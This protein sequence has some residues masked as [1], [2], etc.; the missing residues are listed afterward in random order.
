MIERIL[1]ATSEQTAVADADPNASVIENINKTFSR[2]LPAGFRLWSFWEALPSEDGGSIVVDKYSAIINHDDEESMR[3][4]AN[5]LGVARFPDRADPNYCEIKDV[6]MRSIDDISEQLSSPE[7]IQDELLA[8][9]EYLGISDIEQSEEDELYQLSDAQVENTCQWLLQKPSFIMWSDENAEVSSQSRRCRLLWV[10]G[11]PGSGKTHLSAAVVNHLKPSRNCYYYFLKH[12]DGSK[13]DI[14]GLLKS[15]ALQI[16]RRD[17]KVR[18][19]LLEMVQ[20]QHLERDSS[21]YIV[22]WK[23]VYEKYILTRRSSMQYWVFDAIDEGRGGLNLIELL[24]KIPQQFQCRIFLTSRFDESLDR[25]LLSPDVYH[26]KITYAESREDIRL[27]LQQKADDVLQ[28]API[29]KVPEYIE[30]ILDRSK[31]SFLWTS[32]VAERLASVYAEERIDEVLDNMPAEMNGFYTEILRNMSRSP[33]ID[34]AQTILRWTVCSVRPLTLDQ[35]RLAIRLDLGQNV[36][37]IDAAVRK[38]CGQLVSI[39]QEKVLLAH[40]TVREFLLGSAIHEDEDISQ[41]ALDKATSHARLGEVCLMALGSNVAQS[42]VR[43]DPISR[44]RVN[45]RSRPKISSNLDPFYDYAS[46]YFSEHIVK[47]G[48]PGSSTPV[49]DLEEF[50]QVHVREWIEHAA[51]KGDLTRLIV[52][53]RNLKSF[54]DTRVVFQ[55]RPGYLDVIR[56][57]ADDLIYLVTYFGKFLL[58]VP[59]SIQSTIPPLCPKNSM[60]AHNFGR[61]PQGLEVVGFYPR[62]WAD[63]IS[64]TLFEHDTCSAL[65]CSAEYYAVG[66]KAGWIVAFDAV[67]CQELWRVQKTVDLKFLQ[68]V[69]SSNS[70]VVSSRTSLA[71]YDCED[72]KQLWETPLKLQHRAMTVLED[73][74]ESEVWAFTTK[75]TIAVFNLE[76]GQEIDRFNWKPKS[77]PQRVF[78]CGDELRWLALAYRNQPLE[79][80]ELEDLE[81]TQ[82]ADV[83]SSTETVAFNPTK[84]TLIMALFDGEIRVLQMWNW[85][86]KC[87]IK[88]PVA[89]LACSNDGELVLAGNNSG[90]IYILK[91]DNLECI[92]QIQGEGHEIVSL[93]FSADDRRFIDIRRQLFNIWEPSAL[94][95]RKEVEK[96]S[97]EESQRN[98]SYSTAPSGLMQAFLRGSGSRVTAMALD[99]ARH[100]V[101]CGKENGH[102]T[103]HETTHHGRAKQK[104]YE[105]DGSAVSYMDWSM[106]RQVLVTCDR[107]SRVLVHEV[108]F[109]RQRTSTGVREAWVLGKKLLEKQLDVAVRQVLFTGSGELLMVST[110]AQDCL[111][112]LDDK[113]IF[114]HSCPQS[115][116]T[117]TISQK[118]APVLAR[119]D[120]LVEVELTSVH[121]VTG[122]PDGET[123]LQDLSIDQADGDIFEIAAPH[124]RI[125]RFG[126]GVWAAYDFNPLSRPILWKLPGSSNNDTHAARTLAHLQQIAPSI[127]HLVGEY[128]ARLVFIDVRGWICSVG[129]DYGSQ[130]DQIWYHFPIPHYWQRADHQPLFLVT[131]LGDVV[132]AADEE[133]TV[134]KRGVISRTHIGSL[135]RHAV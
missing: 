71:L 92:H 6:L 133:I 115:R 14:G 107:S 69:S 8:V 53:G 11:S 113:P 121:M 51:S 50:L 22:F 63:R 127:R 52:S 104:L 87:K 24:K 65:A 55:A 28:A 117:G 122:F 76:T 32:L 120:Q 19:W 23:Q 3:L 126:E 38:T 20:D 110:D 16:A 17:A 1:R 95:R 37:R 85:H 134:V 46:I 26:E 116:I 64:S 89:H 27:Y 48:Q 118:W 135:P 90:T 132:L 36:P 61:P 98:T 82:Y 109:S 5:H 129:V 60:M 35:L 25:H 72:G 108:K 86:V 102:V 54:V 123:Q 39:D 62:D 106:N 66:T 58:D 2:Y 10:T 128:Q 96:S 111:W 33:S 44:T 13:H 57:W 18:K 94:V 80:R 47:S 59:S 43:R 4:H 30:K 83:P 77:H 124:V 91:S 125:L 81:Q 73:F 45:A 103:I 12:T 9:A 93:M 97:H 101:F 79:F 119:Q 112:T 21:N 41:F 78:I 105:H 130:S 49:K 42:N 34:L 88:L 29:D 67:T 56:G 100:Y 70:L 99:P 40:E 84:R 114:Q 75:S 74:G 68:F 15:L 31:G 7:R 131:S